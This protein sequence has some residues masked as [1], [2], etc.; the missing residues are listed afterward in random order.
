MES[1][2][3]SVEGVSGKVSFTPKRRIT[4]GRDCFSHSELCL[5]WCD[6]WSCS[7]L[8]IMRGTDNMLRMAKQKDGDH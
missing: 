5:V 8:Q 1:E 2:D 4:T 3:K 7:H 6:A